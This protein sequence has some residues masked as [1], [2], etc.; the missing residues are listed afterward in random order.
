MNAATPATMPAVVKSRARRVREKLRREWGRV[1]FQ[2][3][4]LLM[5]PRV[6]SMP[7]QFVF[8]LGHMRSGSSLLCHLLCNSDEIA[9][10]GETHNNY[11]RRSDLA[12]LLVSIGKYRGKAAL[13]RRYLLD[14]IVGT[15]HVVNAAVLADGRT[16]YVFLVREPLATIASNVAMRRQFHDEPPQQLLAFAVQHYTERLAQLVQLAEAIDDRQRCL[17]LTHQQLIDETPK[18]FRSLEE[19]LDLHAPLSEDYPVMPTTGQ[20]GIGDPSPNIRLGSISRSLPRKH[21]DLSQPLRHR[22]EQCYQNCLAKLRQNVQSI[23]TTQDAARQ[24]AA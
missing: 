14:K 13:E 1:A 10:F 12:K 24:R 3:R 9:G 4:T 17:L 2:A 23:G 6:L 8:I 11:R 16:R 22:L 7:S 19:F 18:A 20:P 15:Q 21:V 5:R